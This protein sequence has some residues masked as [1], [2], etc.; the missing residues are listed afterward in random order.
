[1][2]V[3]KLGA[4]VTVTEQEAERLVPTVVVALMVV[5]PAALAVTVPKPSTVATLVLVDVHVT[6]PLVTLLGE[7]VAVSVEDSPTTKLSEVGLSE[8][9]LAK[10][11]ST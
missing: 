8:M 5:V 3:A 4:F 6:V 11:D 10:I 7:I 2:L 1:M 9:E